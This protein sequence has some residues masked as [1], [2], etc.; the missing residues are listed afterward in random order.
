MIVFPAKAQQ[1]TLRAGQDRI[2]GAPVG[3][4]R[5][6]ASGLGDGGLV[7]GS[8]AA[9][10]VRIGAQHRFPGGDVPRLLERMFQLGALH[11]HAEVRRDFGHEVLLQGSELRQRTVE[12]LGPQDVV[13]FRLDQLRKQH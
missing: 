3:I 5:H 11:L 8:R 1:L 7:A 4:D 10:D 12:F 2:G 13:G 9:K 6:G